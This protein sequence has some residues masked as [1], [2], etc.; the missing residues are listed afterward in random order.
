V[1]NERQTLRALRKR[2]QLVNQAITTLENLASTEQQQILDGSRASR[3]AHSS[4]NWAAAR[5][6]ASKHRKR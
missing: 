2:L 4:S 1:K 3:R 5:Q 6:D